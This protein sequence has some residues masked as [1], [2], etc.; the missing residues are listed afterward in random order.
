MKLR[1]TLSVLVIFVSACG[2]G[3]GGGGGLTRSSTNAS[4]FE[5]TEFN[6]QEGLGI[7]KAQ[8]MFE[9]GGTGSGVIVGVAD[10]GVDVREVSADADQSS[11]IDVDVA[12]S[13]DVVNQVVG[14]ASDEN[15]HGTHVAGI[16]AAPRNGQFMHGIA[17]DAQIANYKI[18]NAAGIVVATDSQLANMLSRARTDGVNIMNNSWGSSVSI[19]ESGAAAQVAALSLYSGE[20]QTYVSSGGVIVFAAGNSSKADPSAEAGIPQ[21]VT[22]LEAGWIVAV[23]VDLNG[24]EP[25]Y[26]NRCGVS[27]NYCIAAPGGGDN[28][29]AQGIQSMNGNGDGLVRLSGTSQAAPHVSGALAALKDL[30]P[31]LTLQQ[32]RARLFTTA[33]KSGIYADATIFGQGLMDLNAASNPVGGL[34]IPIGANSNGPVSGA[35]SGGAQSLQITHLIR[36]P[37]AIKNSLSIQSNILLVDNFQRAPFLISSSNFVQFVDSSPSLQTEFARYTYTKNV[38]NGSGQSVVSSYK[39]GY[40]GFSMDAPFARLGYALGTNVASR[41]PE[42]LGLFFTPKLQSRAASNSLAIGLMREKKGIEYGFFFSDYF[43]QGNREEVELD[44]Y[45]SKFGTFRALS[46]IGANKFN[47]SSQLGLSLTLADNFQ[48]PLGFYTEGV[49]SPDDDKNALGV[50]FNSLSLVG[51]QTISFD[52]DIETFSKSGGELINQER[53]N[54]VTSSIGWSTSIGGASKIYTRSTYEEYLSGETYFR[55]PLGVSSEGVISYGNYQIDQND[56]SARQSF[57]LGWETKR[58]HSLDLGLEFLHQKIGVM[59]EVFG[60]FSRMNY[61]F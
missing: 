61:T 43:A 34:S 7:V 20:A 29:A 45:D 13:F 16:I 28:Q 53:T 31:S 46:L 17:F 8:N 15:G 52:F 47:E 6:A 11:H 25:S 38:K 36:L 4:V 1:I 5:T 23:A 44:D 56:F 22:G 24:L 32:I 49:F 33:N 19:S 42:D 55:L 27:A 18:M 54:I 12:K 2:G 26:T 59:P 57:S 41:F 60:V 40:R 10:S 14:S 9:R 58:S 3:G 35:T 39:D 37:E 50:S 48:Q 21:S 30:F 51:H